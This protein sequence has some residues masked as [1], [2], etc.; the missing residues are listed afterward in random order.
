MDH[1]QVS[2]ILPWYLNA[3]L[4]EE[5]RALVEEH[6]QGCTQCALEIAELQVLEAA[7]N[8]ANAVVNGPSP[9]P[10]RWALSQIRR[11]TGVSLKAPAPQNPQPGNGNKTSGKLVTFPPKN[12]NF[13]LVSRYSAAASIAAVLFLSAFVFQNL[14][15]IPQLK[16]DLAAANAPRAMDYA[17]IKPAHR[18]T[19]QSVELHSRRRAVDLKLDVNWGLSAMPNFKQYRI[20]LKGSWDDAVRH[21]FVTEAAPTLYLSFPS[22]SLKPGLYVLTVT[23]LPEQSDIPANSYHFELKSQEGEQGE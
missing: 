19:L 1:Q 13:G 20:T 18:S 9:Q 6:L 3:T 22:E 12:G 7:V 2:Q 16:G 21:Q 15:T 23:G 10:L 11:T 8:E 5:E 14:W 17:T 4:E